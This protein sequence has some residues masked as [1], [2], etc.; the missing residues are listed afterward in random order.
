VTKYDIDE[1]RELGGIV[2]YVVG[3]N[4][5]PGVFCLAEHSDPKQ[6][7]YLNLYK[8][9]KGPLYS[10]YQ[11]Y[12]LCHFEVHNTVARV[13]LFGDACGTALDQL[14]VEV[15]AVAKRDLA[16]GEVLDGYGEYMTYGEAENSPTVQSDGL[17]PQ[18]L[19]RGCRLRH[20]V[21]KDQLLHWVDVDAP[22]GLARDLYAE[23]IGLGGV[24]V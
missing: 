24:R 7:H 1:L 18:G 3:A 4:P 5:G 20:A 22:N 16:P 2:E 17:L 11:P 10:F 13:V 15:V 19:A 6:R 21:A 23:Q 8:L 12:H 14:S 9:G